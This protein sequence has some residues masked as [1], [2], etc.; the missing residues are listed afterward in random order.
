MTGVPGNDRD[1]PGVHC[2]IAGTTSET[3][4]IAGN[5]GDVRLFLGG[6]STPKCNLSTPKNKI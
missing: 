4:G 6:S 5:S 3:T 2:V 1:W